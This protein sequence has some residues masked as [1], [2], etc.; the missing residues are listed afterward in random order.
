VRTAMTEVLRWALAV[1]GAI[2]LTW[3]LSGVRARCQR[4]L[5]RHRLGLAASAGRD[6]R[7]R[8]ALLADWPMVNPRMAPAV[9]G[10]HQPP[11]PAAAEE[12]R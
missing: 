9:T 12:S 6:V 1:A 11:V 4:R 8:Q 7:D 3:V 5:A 10:Q 2:S